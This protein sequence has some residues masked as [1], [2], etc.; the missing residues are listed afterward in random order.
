MFVTGKDKAGYSLTSCAHRF[1][2]K[3]TRSQKDMTRKYV[4]TAYGLEKVKE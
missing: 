1:R 2:F 3:Q 4:Q